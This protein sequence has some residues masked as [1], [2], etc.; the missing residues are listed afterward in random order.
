MLEWI[1]LIA[2]GI[3]ILAGFFFMVT[4]VVGNFRFKF[5]L[6]RMQAAAMGDTMG[7]FLILVGLAIFSGFQL[8]SLKLLIVVV[9][10]WLSSPVASHLLVL[11]ELSIH[12]NLKI[13]MR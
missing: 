1:R 12:E 7:D 10:H 8:A 4:A 5:V 9:F 3:L 2:G 13:E 11:L 6:S